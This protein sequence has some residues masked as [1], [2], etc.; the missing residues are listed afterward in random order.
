MPLS[1]VVF[2]AYGTLF[3]V[4]SAARKA[5]EDPAGPDLSA[6]W[7]QLAARWRQKQLE[8]T[9]IRAATGHHADFAQVTREALDWTLEAEGLA[10]APGLA[11]RLMALYDRLDAYPEVPEVLHAL[12][13][14]GIRTAILSNGTPAML[15]AAL[16]AADLAGAVDHVLSVEAAGVFKPDRRVYA[17]AT[18]STGVAAGETLYVSA[19]GWDAACAA[20]HGFRSLRVNRDGAPQDRLPDAPEFTLPDLSALP[21]LVAAER[22]RPR[23]GRPAPQH[24]TTGDGLRLAYRDEGSGTPVLCLAGLT[25]NMADFDFVARDFADRARIIRLDTRGRGES[26]F[27]PHYLNYNIVREGQDA[28]ELLDHLGLDRAAILGTSR[29]GLIGLLLTQSHPDRLIGLCL[30]DIGPVIDPAGLAFISSYL[31]VTP[32]HADYEAAADALVASTAATFPGVPRARWRLHA[33]RIWRETGSGLA[34]RYDANLRQSLIERSVIWP[35]TD[36]WPLFDAPAGR[37]VA[38][39]RGVHSDILSA[40]TAAE[41]RRRRPDLIYADVP[42]RGHVPFLDEPEANAVIAAFLEALP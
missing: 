18:A 9:W 36:L 23:P 24:F 32:A 13:A 14:A 3:D 27:D 8:Y 4:A 26:D 17:L 16:A 42:R 39:I 11:D 5:A 34:L 25:R 15:D 35:V 38:L 28:L 6:R 33:E 7:P 29:G 2:D 12:K 40:E 30:N 10:D 22:A 21:G 19:N 20:A 41:M 31:G 37:P 1:C